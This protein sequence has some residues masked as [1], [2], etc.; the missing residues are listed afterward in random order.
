MILLLGTIF[1]QTYKANKKI[2]LRTIHHNKRTAL[3]NV[4]KDRAHY[5]GY[6]GARNTEN[7][8]KTAILR[9]KQA[10]GI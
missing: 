7:G 9:K 4:L 3:K 2:H 5:Y 1:G 8:A 6:G 10:A